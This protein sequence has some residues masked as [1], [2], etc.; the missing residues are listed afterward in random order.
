MSFPSLNAESLYTNKRD[1]ARDL[2]SPVLSV[3]FHHR[4]VDR[5][6]TE[7][8]FS[9]FLRADRMA[10]ADPV[11][12]IIDTLTQKEFA[13][14]C[15]F[16]KCSRRSNKK[17]ARTLDISNQTLRNHSTTIFKKMGVKNRFEL[18]ILAKR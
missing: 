18:Y 10:P 17:I 11:T 2:V 14:M 3:S 15:A 4:E 16:A 5:R 1:S 12:K 9:K 13:I 7:R 6:T 8:I